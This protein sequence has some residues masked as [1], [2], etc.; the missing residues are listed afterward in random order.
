VF[1]NADLIWNRAALEK[2]GRAARQGDRALAGLLEAHGLIANGGVVHCLEVLDAAEISAAI[3]GY[4]YF[5]FTSAADLLVYAGDTRIGELTEDLW[6][7]LDERYWL[8]VENDGAL[9]AAF[10]RQFSALPDEFAPV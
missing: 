3:A 10:E 7:K 8:I 2:G 6:V 4:R 5:G 9:Q 1:S